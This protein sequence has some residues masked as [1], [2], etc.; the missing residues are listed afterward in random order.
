MSFTRKGYGRI[1]VENE[2]DIEK[3]D[4]IIKEVDEFEYYYLPSKYIA[5][6]SEYPKVIYTHKFDDI[7][8][9]YLTALCWHRGIKIF[10]LDN[11]HSEYVRDVPEEILEAQ[12]QQPT[13]QGVPAK[14]QASSH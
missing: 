5:H 8:I 4:K 6:F 11:G 10:C 2:Q 13:A 14:E 7:D 1:Y 12:K 9:N 3:V